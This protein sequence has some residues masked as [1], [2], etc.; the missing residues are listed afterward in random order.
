MLANYET[1]KEEVEL[2]M[3]SFHHVGLLV[4]CI[5][6]AVIQYSDLFGKSNVSGIITITSQ[7][8]KVCF[9]KISEASFI[10]L[11]EPIDQKSVVYKLL[12]KRI[13]Y[14]HIGYKVADILSAVSRLEKLNYKP[15]NFFNSEA[16]EGKRCIFLFTPDAYLIEL[17]EQ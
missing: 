2:N 9:V 8:V 10:E 11:V 5:E 7:R 12:K 3:L 4:E 16:F 17:V 6:N 15:L 13:N 1:Y 14:Y